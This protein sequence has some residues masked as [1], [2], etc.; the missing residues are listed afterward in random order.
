MM[1]TMMATTTMMT[2]TTDARQTEPRKAIRSMVV[3]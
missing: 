2:A 1:T 3:M